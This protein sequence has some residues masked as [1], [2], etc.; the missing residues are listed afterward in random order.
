MEAFGGGDK[1]QRLRKD[2]GDL[3][4]PPISRNNTKTRR[5][6]GSLSASLLFFSPSWTVTLSAFGFFSHPLLLCGKKHSLSHPRPLLCQLAS[7][8]SACLRISPQ[9]IRLNR[10][11]VAAVNYPFN[12]PISSISS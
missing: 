4:G 3:S 6:E 9:Q 2:L 1:L 12:L 11:L 10:H 7:C 8:F 5:S